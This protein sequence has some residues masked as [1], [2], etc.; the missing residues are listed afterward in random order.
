MLKRY[1]VLINDW[2]VEHL[3][4]VAERYD[5]SFSEVIRVLLCLKILELINMRYPKCKSKIK[6]SEIA[7]IVNKRANVKDFDTDE[8]HKF[9][10]NVYFETRKA[11]ECWNSLEK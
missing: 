2:L 4:L 9:L 7:N 11:I 6:N 8:L 10:S 5:I 3:K 1:Q